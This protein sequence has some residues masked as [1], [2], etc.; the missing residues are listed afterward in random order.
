MKLSKVFSR[1]KTLFYFTMWDDSDR[2]GYKDFLGYDVRAN[3][4]C[5]RKGSKG[6]V[7][8]SQEDLRVIDEK[9]TE[10]LSPEFLTR[11]HERLDEEWTHLLPY[12]KEDRP[13]KTADDLEDYYEHLVRW[14]SAMNT[15]FNIP[16]MDVAQ[17]F[18]DDILVV[19]TESEKYTEQMNKL[20]IKFWQQYPEY[21]DVLFFVQPREAIQ[22]ARGDTSIVKDIRKRVNGCCLFNTRI[23]LDESVLQEHHIV[24]EEV[25]SDVSEFNGSVAH[26]GGVITG[27]VRVI[28]SFADRESFQDGEVLVTEMTNPDYVPIMKRAAA[29]ITDEG[30]ITC[31][32]AIA[33]R[34][35]GV[36]CIIATKVATKVLKNGDEVVVDTNAGRV[37][38]VE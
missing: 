10:Q 12:L 22:I 5:V 21:E 34:E 26:N 23:Y 30:G 2:M 4:F 14:W 33:S 27:V 18:K 7:W 25:E 8:Y 32:A 28:S 36:P 37:R 38:K 9:I 13:I 19:R 24:L 15:V 6:E 31:H 1:E 29:I 35:L 20:F 11:I 16:D 17:E 3:F